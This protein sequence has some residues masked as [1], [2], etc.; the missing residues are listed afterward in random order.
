MIK[1]LV[2]AAV[3][4]AFAAP[5]AA[6]ASAPSDNILVAQSGGDTGASS[7]QP[8]V[9]PPGAAAPGA[10]S[11]SVTG[12]D[13]DSGAAA[14]TNPHGANDAARSSSGATASGFERL[15]K[16]RDGFVTRDEAN[17]ASELHTR[18]TELD[19]NNDGKLSRDEYDVV[20][21]GSAGA[22]SAPSSMDRGGTK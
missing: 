21:R 16:N 3:A 6:Q 12:T 10:P 20:N 2:A 9:N 1:T 18:F 19:K 17:D 22:T 7:R 4:A 5:L 15:Y 14:R 13:R 8:G 11:T